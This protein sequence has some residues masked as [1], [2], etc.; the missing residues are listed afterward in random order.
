MSP[1]LLLL[2]GQLLFNSRHSRIDFARDLL[3]CIGQVSRERSVEFNEVP[4]QGGLDTGAKATKAIFE[5][6]LGDKCGKTG[7]R[8][9][10]ACPRG[11]RG[12]FGV[13]PFVRGGKR[14]PGI[15]IGYCGGSRKGLAKPWVHI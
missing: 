10:R 14:T 7:G 4:L 13:G 8:R 1:E 2:N 15:H 11:S 6:L 9:C 12:N 3:N 5:L